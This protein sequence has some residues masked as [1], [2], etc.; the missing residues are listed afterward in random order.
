MA[1]SISP[2]LL[3]SSQLFVGLG[4]GGVAHLMSRPHLLEHA[5]H[6]K[7]VYKVESHPVALLSCPDLAL[8]TCHHIGGRTQ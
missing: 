2:F 6:L 1:R 7:L 3:E 5:L 8:K 4:Q